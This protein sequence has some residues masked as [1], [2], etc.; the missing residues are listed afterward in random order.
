MSEGG[1][2]RPW[3]RAVGSV[4]GDGSAAPAGIVPSGSSCGAGSADGAP[5]LERRVALAGELLGSTL[6]GSG[7]CLRTR[8]VGLAALRVVIARLLL[9]QAAR[10]LELLVDL[11]GDPAEL[12]EPLA[13][14]T[15]DL[16]QALR[17]E[18]DQSDDQDDRELGH[19]D[20]EHHRDANRLCPLRQTRCM[21][22]G[23]HISDGAEADPMSL[24]MSVT[25][26]EAFLSEVHVAVVSIPEP[27]RGGL[28]V[29]IWYDYAPGGPL[30]FVTDATSRKAR[31]LEAAGCLSVCVQ[32]EQAPYKYVSVEGPVRSIE[33][34]DV[35]RD[36][37]P[38]AHR[39]LGRDVGDRYIDAT[40]GAGGAA[41]SVVVRIDL[42]RW[43]SV[44]YA[45]QFGDA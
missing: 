22:G 42:R 8:L 9:D 6:R 2:L 31:L 45:K 44:D 17:S 41:A 24:A 14:G 3:G 30:W 5:A 29:P 13:E 37:R 18:H 39:Y 40:M 35:E 33:P 23:V 28:A 26:R 11:A 21:S 36:T 20:T 7:L 43:L 16:G 25:E 1:G 19:A 15:R 32:S 27:G 34:A 4:V 10:A 38:L 12:G